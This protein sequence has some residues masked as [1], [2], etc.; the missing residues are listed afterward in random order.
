MHRPRYA[1]T[2]LVEIYAVRAFANMYPSD[3]TNVTINMVSP[4][5]C[6]TGLARDTRRVFRV[7]QGV[8]RAI[9]ARTA[10]QG[11]RTVL[12]AL[13]TEEATHGKHLSG[14]QVKE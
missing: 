4:G 1:L 11:S 8:I 13:L 6:S 5:I 7:I 10:E 9:T 3:K 12:H 2:K 14:C